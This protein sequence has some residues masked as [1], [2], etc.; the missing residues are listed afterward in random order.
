MPRS[1]P[2]SI[3]SKRAI[4]MNEEGAIPVERPT[5]HSLRETFTPKK[6]TPRVDPQFGLAIWPMNA[7]SLARASSVAL[8]LVAGSC[9]TTWTAWPS[10][11]FRGACRHHGNEGISGRGREAWQKKSSVFE[12][13]P[14]VHQGA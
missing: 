8:R 1:A 2:G 6:T 4:T 14:V 13:F 7:S 3:Q 11:G 9:W 12:D 5:P 10:G